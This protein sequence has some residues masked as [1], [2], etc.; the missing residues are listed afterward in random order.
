VAKVSA[1]IAKV[2]NSEEQLHPLIRS[3]KDGME[4]VYTIPKGS[5]V[6]IH[7]GTSSRYVHMV[8]V[9]I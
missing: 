1:S 7:E 8:A 5:R 4:H 9:G 6:V 2:K 3:G